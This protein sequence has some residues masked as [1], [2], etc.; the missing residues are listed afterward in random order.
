[1]SRLPAAFLRAPIAH[2]ALHD[3][4][5]ARPEN[6]RAAIAAAIAAGYGIEIDVQP[7]A[8]GIPMV[9]HDEELGRLCG[10]PGKIAGTA[11]AELEKTHVLGT[12]ETIPRL[13]EVLA[14]V[15][16]RVPLLVEIKDQTGVL[17]PVDG[18]FERAVG[19]ELAAY[20]GLVAAMSFN[21]F[22][23]AAFAAAAPAVARGLVTCSFPAFYWPGLPRP[24]AEELAAIPDAE[25]LA[26]DFISHQHGEL[27][28]TRVRALRAKGLPVL[29]WTVRSL[30]AELQARLGADNI[31]FE[32]Y[33]AAV[34]AA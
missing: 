9:F 18:G 26:V 16:G 33:E 5:S 29:C 24:R 28:S 15:A 27:A 20:R 7:S 1:M 22:S 13:A 31:T 4:A 30:E 19:A 2:R 8:E 25:G 10:R 11:A 14:L 23:V 17:G 6:T 32:G 34:A 12:R 21:P 3:A